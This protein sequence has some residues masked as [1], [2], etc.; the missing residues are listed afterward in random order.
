MQFFRCNIHN[1]YNIYYYGF[2]FCEILNLLVTVIA[3]FLTNRFLAGRYLDYGIR[4]FQYYQF[5]PE[6][7]ERTGVQNP[8]CYTF[9]RIASCDWHRFGSA[10]E[11]ENINAICVLALNIIND[12]VFLIIW[13]W[14]YILF[15][16][17]ISR[18]IFRI[19]QI[20]SVR[21][22]FYMINLRMHR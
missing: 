2:I 15:F 7:K 3:Y 13:W 19:V 4:V 17:G 12:K 14:Y 18:L 21:L 1:K 8:M 6:E 20:N 9:P 5:P 22:R 11:Q 16:L 10:G